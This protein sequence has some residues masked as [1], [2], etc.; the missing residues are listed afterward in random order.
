[1]VP[2]NDGAEQVLESASTS[3]G[4]PEAASRIASLSGLQVPGIGERAKLAERIAHDIEEDIIHAGWPVGEI[5]ASETEL[6]ERYSV[7]R[8]VLREAVRILEGHKVAVMK[9]GVGGGLLVTAPDESSVATSVALFL[10]HSRVTRSALLD[11]RKILE[12]DCV[13]LLATDP[14]PDVIIRLRGLVKAEELAFPERLHTVSHDLH[15]E[16]AALTQNPALALFVRVLSE[17]SSERV[18]YAVDA[19]GDIAREVHKAH[20][21]IVEAIA[22]GEPDLAEKRLARHLDAVGTRLRQ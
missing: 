17:I 9:R 6:A 15:L 14:D 11:I 20:R 13:R 1:V 3:S 8:A 10:E 4:M 2:H 12:V 22:A 7:S 19:V 5:F 16:M 21:L 18:E